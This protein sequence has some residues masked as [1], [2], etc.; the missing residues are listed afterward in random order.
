[1]IFT[2]FDDKVYGFGDNIFA[3]L[4]METPVKVTDPTVIE[5]LCGTDI[6][7]VEFG[8]QFMVVLTESH[9]LY[10]GGLVWAW[11]MWKWNRISNTYCKPQKILIEDQL[12]V[13]IRCGLYYTVLLTD[14]QQVYTFGSFDGKNSVLTPTLISTFE[15][16][17]IVSISCGYWHALALNQYGQVYAWGCNYH[18]QLGL[19]TSYEDNENK[20]KLDRN[21]E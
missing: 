7:K 1:M 15:F 4:G 13:D 19:N 3:I 6:K 17:N 5:E 21:A 11:Q 18:G 14:K 16:D 9:E 2:T 20:P 10:T 12:I 8:Y